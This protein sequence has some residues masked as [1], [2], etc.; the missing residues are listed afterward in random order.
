[1][2]PFEDKISENFGIDATPIER[3]EKATKGSFAVGTGNLNLSLYAP[4]QW[5]NGVSLNYFIPQDDC[6]LSQILSYDFCKGMAFRSIS[7]DYDSLVLMTCSTGKQIL[8]SVAAHQHLPMGAL[9]YLCRI[10]GQSNWMERRLELPCNRVA[11]EM[12]ISQ[13]RSVL[14]IMMWRN[15]RTLFIRLYQMRGMWEKEV[16]RSAC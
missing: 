5:Q 12:E 16:C 3:L 4:S 13:G 15:M 11:L 9:L 14:L 10:M 2:I 1:M 7:D 6:L 8:R